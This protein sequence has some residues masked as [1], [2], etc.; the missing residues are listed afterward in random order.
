MDA[1]AVIEALAALEAAA[2]SGAPVVIQSVA[3]A[4]A[5]VVVGIGEA[6]YGFGAEAEESEQVVLTTAAEVVAAAAA[7]A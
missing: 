7:L 3:W 4:E 6:D 1:V 5:G 2:A